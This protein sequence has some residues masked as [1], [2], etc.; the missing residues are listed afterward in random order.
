MHQRPA[1]R[2]LFERPTAIQPAEGTFDQP[3]LDAARRYLPV[4]RRQPEPERTPDHAKARLDHSLSD[5]PHLGRPAKGNELGIRGDVRDERE[6]CLAAGGDNGRTLDSFHARQYSGASPTDRGWP[7]IGS[8]MARKKKSQ[9]GNVIA[10]NRRARFD[11]QLEDRLEAGLALEGWEVKSLRSGR[12]QISEGYV[13]FREG[14]AFLQGTHI[15]PLPS[16]S[17]HV[18]TDPV[19]PR[20][21]LL[22]RREIDR[23]AAAVQREGYTVV[24]L[25]LHWSRGRA[26]LEI[27]T[28]KGKRR[29]DKRASDRDRDWRRERERLMKA[30]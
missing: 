25:D 5:G 15:S 11:Y 23:L 26:K 27:A 13:A 16:A 14:E 2:R 17:T 9:G 29:T 7:G 6:R 28:A 22:H 21:L 8:G 12:A 24:P 3:H 10:A 1:A 30:R 20:R 18:E 19:R 4:A